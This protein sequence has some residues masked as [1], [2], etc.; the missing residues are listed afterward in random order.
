L[1]ANTMIEPP[2]ICR[3]DFIKHDF[4][5]TTTDLIRYL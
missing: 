3:N 5:Y 2:N 4:Y 1:L